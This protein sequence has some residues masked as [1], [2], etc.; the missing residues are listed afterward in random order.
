[1]PTSLILGSGPAAAG[2][3]WHS[4]GTRSSASRCWTWGHA[5]GA[6]T[7]PHGA[8]TWRAG[9][10]PTGRRPTSTSSV[11][12]RCGPAGRLPEKRAFGLGLPVPGPRTAVRNPRRPGRQR[13]VGLRCL[14]GV[15]QRVGRPDHAL[16]SGDV[17]RLAGVLR[18]D[19][20]PLPG[21]SRRDGTGR[22]GG[23]SRR[24]VPAPHR[25]PGLSR[26]SV[27]GQRR[28][29]RGH[30]AHRGRLQSRG[31]DR[32]PGPPGAPRRRVHPVRPVHDRL[33]LPADL[34][35]RP[36][37]ST[38]SAPRVGSTTTTASWP[39]GW[40]R[41]PA[42]PSSRPG[43]R[44]GCRTPLVGRPRSSWRAAGSAPRRLVLGSLGHFD[45]P[46]RL[47][48]SVQFLLPA[49]SLRPTPDP[50]R[51]RTFT[52]NQFNLVFDAGGGGRDLSQIHFY[53]YNPAIEDVGPRGPPARP[54]RTGADRCAPPPVDRAR[55]PPVLGVAPPRGRGPI[56]PQWPAYRNWTCTAGRPTAGP[57]CSASSP[58][59]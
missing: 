18:R 59:P 39:C 6:A 12:G 35:R 51:E 8:A 36:T 21:G 44:L 50:R 27:D 10:R 32:R 49:L 13:R 14:R 25:R 28:C 22:R 1:M 15:L 37:P 33:P 2:R 48:E 20:A 38:D 58:G 31:R 46:V 26:P 41:S 23:R 29:W 53:P 40:T 45:R 52:L 55:L 34:L 3:H 19:G 57:G 5:R 4:P 30:D 7:R 42:A 54:R 24:P 17:R 56:G 16:Q 43:R 9:R 47:L 11:A